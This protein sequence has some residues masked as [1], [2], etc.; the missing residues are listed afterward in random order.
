MSF[1]TEEILWLLRIIFSITVICTFRIAAYGTVYYVDERLGG[2]S[3][4]GTSPTLPW[5]TLL[6]VSYI[7]LSPGDKV[8]LHRGA[9]WKETL[10]IHSSGDSRKP[11]TF[12]A[13]GVGPAPIID[14]ENKRKDAVHIDGENYITIQDLRLQNAT[15]QIIYVHDCNTCTI[16]NNLLENSSQ[17][18]I[19]AEGSTRGLTV[20]DNEY[21][22]NPGKSM[23]GTA[24]AVSSTAETSL[25]IANNTIDLSNAAMDQH[26][27]AIIIQDVLNPSIYGNVILGGAQGIGI[28][29]LTR[30]VTGVQIYDNSI[31]DVTPMTDGDGE[32]IELTGT[33]SC[34]FGACHGKFTVSGSIYRN[35]VKGSPKAGN[36]SSSVFATHSAVYRN[37]IIG[38]FAPGTAAF[39]WSSGCLSNVFY[40]NTIYDVDIG[41]AIYS[42]SSATIKNNIV[43]RSSHHALAAETPPVASTIVE[44]YNDFF[45]SGT[46]GNSGQITSGGHSIT[47]D[48]RFVNPRPSIS[49]D[50]KLRPDSPAI[51]S[52]I[53]LGKPYSIGLDPSGTLFPYPAVERS[54]PESRVDMGAFSFG[55]PP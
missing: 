5:R 11:I 17:H 38:P 22:L 48:P 26:P 28:K 1:P 46:F 25:V 36:A 53:N 37:L 2:D 21:R 27:A 24:I 54:G 31:S 7:S 9:V 32:A 45:R 19:L 49:N 16:R 4:P 44:D 33:G 34:N 15:F 41:F 3:N 40:N 13:Y 52:G 47:S 35:Y 20:L 23:I 10:R 39:H 14:A 12:G 43:G 8:F 30:N 6:R 29:A 42:G 51:R 50:L 18:G 55:Y